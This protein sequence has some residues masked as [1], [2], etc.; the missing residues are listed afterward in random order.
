MSDQSFRTSPVLGVRNVRASAEYYRDVLG[1]HLDPE[2]GVFAGLGDETT[3]VY[4]IVQR[5]GASV[6]FQIRR[7]DREAGERERIETD[8]YLHVEDV[9]ALHAEFEQA[10]AV[11]WGPP[12]VAPYGMREIRVEDPDGHRLTFGSPVRS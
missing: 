9:G 7:G 6:H 5:G 12:S 3:G 2:H 4:A 10:G 1:F 8:I 11:I